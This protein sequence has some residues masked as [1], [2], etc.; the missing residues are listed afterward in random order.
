MES[1]DK[2]R[3]RRK[4][5]KKKKILIL[6]SIAVLVLSVSLVLGMSYKKLEN[7]KANAGVIDNSKEVNDDNN[8][9]VSQIKNN[10]SK[11]EKTSITISAVGDCTLGE[12]IGFGKAGTFS[13]ELRRQNN[14]YSYFFENV[15]EV[16]KN[17]DITIANLE[18]TLTNADIRQE[19]TFA[20]KGKPEYTKILQ[21]GDVDVVNVANNHTYDYLEDGFKD[22]IL[23]LK[24][25]KVGYFGMGRNHIENV[26]G[27]RIGFL[28]YKVWDSPAVIKKQMKKD[29]D[30]IKKDV[31]L[32]IISFHWG[33][34]MQKFPNDIQRE[35]GRYAINNG[36]DLVIGHHPHVIQGIEKYKDKFIVYSLGN[37]SF[38]GN[39]NPKDKD[40]FIFQ[41]S[42]NF[43]SDGQLESSS[44][45]NII[46]CSISSVSDRN[47]YRPTILTGTEGERV[48]ERIKKASSGIK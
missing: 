48:L 41:Q 42:F 1:K 31:N 4:E 37:F 10:N 13:D 12:D 27:I 19:K 44:D 8:Q 45:M 21:L 32:L 43:K 16:F 25:A 35:L 34:E 2:I 30:K 17:D 36:A 6:L 33:N 20:F 47:D 28:G 38:G 5:R 7:K 15:S 24:K 40:T 23:N 14:D 18:G 3:Q 39:K 11:V 9:V 29:M 26:K 46:P 22:T